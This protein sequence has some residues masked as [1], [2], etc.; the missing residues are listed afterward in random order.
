MMQR[1]LARKPAQASAA[2]LRA[3]SAL[4]VNEPGDSFEQEADRV[5]DAVISGRR[6]PSW[7]IARIAMGAVQRDTPD[8]SGKQQQPKPNNY[9]EAGQKLLEAAMQTDAGKKVIE[10]VEKDPLVK[11]VKDFVASTPGIIVTGAAAVGAVTGLASTHKPLPAQLPGVPVDKVIPALKGVKAQIN[12]QGPLDHPTQITI[13]FSGTFGGGG[14]AKKKMNSSSQQLAR[15]TQ[16]LKASMDMFK[17]RG[18]GSSDDVG[19]LLKL[20]KGAATPGF[21]VEDCGARKSP[22]PLIG[23]QGALLAPAQYPADAPLASPADEGP[24]EKKE[25]EIPLQRSQD[26]S[27]PLL[28]RECSCGGSGDSNG[29]CQACKEKKLQRKVSGAAEMGYAPA[30]VHDVLRSPGTPL[31][32]A[33]RSF[34]EPR[35][36]VDFSNVRIHSDARAAESARSV[37]ALAYTVGDDVVFGSGQYAPH[38]ATGGKLLAHE[39]THV[40]QQGDMLPT[41]QPRRIG[42]NRDS[43][44]SEAD[45]KTGAA[46]LAFL[47]NSA[48]K[49]PFERL[50]SPSVQRY[51]SGEHAKFGETGDA[52]KDLA[53]KAWAYKVKAGEM[54]S[55][56]ARRFQ[57]TEEELRAANPNKWRNWP[58]NADPTKKVEGFNAGEKILVPPTLNDAIKEAL[59]TKEL[60]LVVNGV[61]LEYGQGISMGDFYETPEQM[62][63]APPA[64]LQKLS[65]LIEKEKGGGSVS[66]KEWQDATGG[67]Y[68]KLAEKNES[69]FAP[70]NPVLAPYSGKSLVNH[71]EEWEK[72]HTKALNKSRA[73]DKDQALAMNSFGDHF[74]TDAFAAGHL[75]NKRDVMEK[76][77]GNM[78]KTAGGGFAPAS[79]AFFDFR[80]QCHVRWRGKDRVLHTDNRRLLFCVRQSPRGPVQ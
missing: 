43:F 4:R 1:A 72:I 53:P 61:T 16:A 30:I 39:L 34:F 70:S 48:R 31:D 65:E 73:G 18:Q 36:G 24:H 80:L 60:A 77:E 11:D 50:R 27:P 22:A 78:P 74:L 7:S 38:S 57:I 40:A 3:P 28:Q 59:K 41:A 64:E 62:L 55:Q 37:G 8:D 12:V 42:R 69:H 5:A 68:L 54:P 47:S 15:E 46:G 9:A 21:S 51:A 52:L 56:L 35:F 49:T 44:E 2:P 45:K 71:K 66:T 75:I 17:P 25:D 6:V 26:H 76:F 23:T 63:A 58:S 10:K 67:R 32:N 79:T 14:S 20:G 19:E 29:E 13:G 33:T